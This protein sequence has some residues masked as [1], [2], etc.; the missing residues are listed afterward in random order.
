MAYRFMQANKDRYPVRE[1]A[2]LLGVT[3]GAYYKWRK[4]GVSERRDK[5]DAELLR[6]IREIQHTHYDRYGSP[7]VRETGKP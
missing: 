5:R 3:S 7:R 1:M 4:N 2:G 6:L